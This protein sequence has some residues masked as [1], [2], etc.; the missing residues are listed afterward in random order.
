MEVVV[1]S[2]TLEVS[3]LILAI[4][5]IHDMWV[6][7]KMRICEPP[8]F[9]VVILQALFETEL[10]YSKLFDCFFVHI[11]KSLTAGLLASFQLTSILQDLLHSWLRYHT[12]LT[13][14]VARAKLWLLLVTIVWNGNR[15]CIFLVVSHTQSLHI[16]KDVVFISNAHLI[17]L[18]LA[19][20]IVIFS[21][22][23]FIVVVFIL[24]EH[25]LGM[26]VAADWVSFIKLKVA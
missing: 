14:L 4:D 18:S 17:I 3:E 15:I 6:V 9:G 16:L 11:Q 23:S 8:K 19:A 5:S 12:R 21:V 7:N 20:K 25:V 1:S 26:G 13:R 10:G 24:V 2:F 22:V